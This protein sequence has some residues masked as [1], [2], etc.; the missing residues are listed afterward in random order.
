MAARAGF[1]N[2]SYLNM[3]P[4]AL[5]INLIILQYG[6]QARYLNYYL[7]IIRHSKELAKALGYWT[8]N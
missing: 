4:K 6:G 8:H 1:L 5:S 7:N 2:I 3:A